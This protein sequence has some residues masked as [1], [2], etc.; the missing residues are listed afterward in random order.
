MSEAQQPEQPDQPKIPIEK[1]IGPLVNLA[2]SI[3]VYA[4]SVSPQIPVSAPNAAVQQNAAPDEASGSTQVAS[5]SAAP[6]AASGSAPD[7]AAQT[8]DRLA[9]L[10]AERLEADRLNK[11]APQ[12]AA[13]S[14]PDTTAQ[15]QGDQVEDQE[16]KAAQAAAVPGANQE[17]KAAQGAQEAAGQGGQGDQVAQSEEEKLKAAQAAEADR[18][19]AERLEAERLA[20]AERL[21]AKEAEEKLKKAEEE[22]LKAEKL[23]AQ[24]D[25]E[26]AQA[27]AVPA[28]KQSN[29]NIK[30]TGFEGKV[31]TTYDQIMNR[32][33]DKFFKQI[34][35]QIKN[36]DTTEDQ[37]MLRARKVKYESVKKLLEAATTEAEVNKIIND[38]KVK[39]DSNSITS[40]GTRKPRMHR[41]KKTQRKRSKTIKK[42]NRAGKRK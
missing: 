11:E 6:D 18:L 13:G 41:R 17:E 25:Q 16:E 27:E 4:K 2:E 19:E 7:A 24:G 37:E 23:K 1:L 15:G 12:V 3:K 26:A 31:D 34:D 28:F 8:A 32:K 21:K 40:G 14:A 42:K 35:A 5:G 22:K 29:S 36:A 20:E 9:K 30:F 10:E 39:F 33:I 38:N